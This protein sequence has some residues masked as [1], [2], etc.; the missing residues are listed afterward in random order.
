MRNQ[1]RARLAK[2]LSRLQSFL[3]YRMRGFIRIT[4]PQSPV[5]DNLRIL[6]QHRPTCRTLVHRQRTAHDF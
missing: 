4:T 6:W 1:Q 5:G 2:I 3:P